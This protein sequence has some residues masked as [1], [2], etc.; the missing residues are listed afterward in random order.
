MTPE[1]D[2]PLAVFVAMPDKDMGVNARWKDADE[3]RKHLLQPVRAALERRLGRQVS[4]KVESKSDVGASTHREMY[5]SALDADV[6]IADLTG[7]NANVYL[8]LGVRWALCDRVTIPICQDLDADVKFNVRPAKVIR[9]GQ[10]P[11]ALEEAKDRLLDRILTTLQS[12]DAIDSL[13]RVH[14]PDLVTTTRGE[15][16]ARTGE[17]ADLKDEIRRLRAGR[18]DELLKAALAEGTPQ[19]LRRRHLEEA[20]EINPVSFAAHFEL[21]SLEIREGNYEAAVRRLSEATRL[22]RESY[23][24]WRLLGV[25]YGKE[26]LL[27]EARRALEK[28]LNLRSDE[29]ETWSNLGGYRRR[30]ARRKHP[31][32]FDKGL[33]RDAQDAYL[34][35]N[36]IKQSDTYSLGNVARISLILAAETPDSMPAAVEAFEML[37][38]AARFEVRRT[39]RKDSWK[40]FDLADALAFAGEAEQA[41]GCLREAAR[42]IPKEERPDRFG[43]YLEPLEDI[44]AVNALDD[45]RRA[46]FQR[47]ADVARSFR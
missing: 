47:L 29:S 30:A 46:A 33:L 45:R 8:E 1:T 17:I 34:K 13:V 4:L 41:E 16:S 2:R 43:G 22:D 20:L 3:I 12:D 23:E 25:A 5:R 37:L 32:E 11:A 36:S 21:G 10:G 7:A 31:G 18:G 14:L 35:A 24:A 6:Y 39:R 28:A 15:L 26:N 44:L 38:D 27:D 19:D 40:L 9:Y 42:L